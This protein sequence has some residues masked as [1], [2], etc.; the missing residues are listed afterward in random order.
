MGW[1]SRKRIK[2]LPGV[3]LNVSKSGNGRPIAASPPR[4]RVALTVF[5]LLVLLLGTLAVALRGS[6]LLGRWGVV[7]RAGG[8]TVAL[9]GPM[10]RV[11]ELPCAHP[12]AVI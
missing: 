5:L 3:A 12:S 10:D 9:L 4:K 2:A 8:L 1:T 6:V 7:G 11:S